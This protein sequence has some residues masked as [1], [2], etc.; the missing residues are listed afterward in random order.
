MNMSFASALP[1]TSD[2]GDTMTDVF[3]FLKSHLALLR[4]AEQSGHG[5][6]YAELNV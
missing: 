5:I 2:D 4:V 6:A 3:N 1:C